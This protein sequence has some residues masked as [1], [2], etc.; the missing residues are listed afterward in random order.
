M[1]TRILDVG[2]GT[3]AAAAAA[4]LRGAEVAAVDAEPD[5]LRLAARAAGGARLCVGALP[6][7][8]FADDAF[9]AVVANF[10]L[11]HVGRPRVALAELR[12]VTAPGGTVAVTIWSGTEAGFAALLRDA[13]LSE[14]SCSTLYWDHFTDRE[15]WWSGPAVGLAKIGQIL[16]NQ[17][18]ETIARVRRHYERLSERFAT[19]DGRMALPHAAFLAVGRA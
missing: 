11:N 6:T 4:V 18:N 17:T 1:G 19:P 5:M 12:R 8:P 13:G 3:G 2:T 14:V 15:E 9:A 7:L 10:V 16:T